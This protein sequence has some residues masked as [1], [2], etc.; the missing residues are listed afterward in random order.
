MKE[1]RSRRDFLKVGLTTAVAGAAAATGLK[2]LAPGE[3]NAN[4]AQHPYGAVILDVDATRQLGYNGYK[5]IVLEDGVK[6]KDCAF[7]TFNAIIG[8]LAEADPDGPYAN[9]PTQMM[10]WA[11]G[12]VAGFATLCGALNGACAAIGLICSNSDAKPF[13]SDLLSWY[14]EASLPTNIVAPTGDLPQSVAGGN[15]CH[16]SVTNW[17]RRSGFASGS[18]ERSERCARVAGDVAAKVVEMLN[19]GELGLPTPADKTGCR[20]C[21]YKGTDYNAG[22]FT[23]G[24]MDCTQCH[25]VDHDHEEEGG[26]DREE[27]SSR[28]R[29]GR[30]SRRYDD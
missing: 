21:H 5:G 16:M 10:E 1:E 17:C 7:G 3:A 13:I 27:Y 22:Q 4:S 20:S 19:D 25:S 12:G 15:L 9:I 28:E 30:R 29:G 14:A 11:S 24:Q 6:H 8:Q 18:S 26:G 2:V 23:R